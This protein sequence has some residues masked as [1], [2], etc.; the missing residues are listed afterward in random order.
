MTTRAVGAALLALV[1]ACAGGG[2]DEGPQVVRVYSP[3]AT[4]H[5]Y[6]LRNEE[7]TTLE[8]ARRI[9]GT[10]AELR[11]GGAIVIEQAL[12]SG[13][14][15]A[16]TEAE[17]SQYDFVKGDGA[18]AADYGREGDVLVARDWETF[19]M[20]TFYR[21]MERARDFF[22]ELGAQDSEVRALRAHFNL[23]FTSML[24][25]WGQPLLTD[26]AAYSMLDDAF[27]LPPENVT[28]GLALA[29]N[30]GVVA[31]E[32]SHAVKHH[33]LHG[34]DRIPRPISEAWPNAAANAYSSDDEGLADFFAA[35]FT[36][37]PDFIRKSFAAGIDRDL[38]DPHPFTQELY[39]RL[40]ADAYD[41]YPLGSALAAWLWALSDDELEARRALAANVLAAVRAVERDP[42]YS[43]LAFME[44]ILAQ[45]DDAGRARGCALLQVRLEGDFRNLP[46]CDIGAD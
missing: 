3:L 36:N 16:D 39:D 25:A 8:S 37:D 13:Q 1:A 11:G 20:F 38:T 17:V 19:Q 45:L 10:A 23:R 41:P 4:D 21:H 28:D 44:A 32:L 12:L 24:L 30:A 15:T 31:H 22:R 6:E 33:V 34:D 29:L 14:L 35:V 2:D 7:L 9:R 43:M 40:S 27:W 5:T 46:A 26:N 42:D 18:V